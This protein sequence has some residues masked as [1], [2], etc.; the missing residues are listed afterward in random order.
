MHFEITIC[1]MD[2]NSFVVYTDILETL[3]ELNDEEVGRL[4]R[5]MVEYVEL[6]NK[7][8]FTGKLRLT[9]IPIRQ[10]LDRDAARWEEIRVKRSEAGRI[11][12]QNSAKKR[13]IVHGDV[14]GALHGD[15]SKQANA[16]NAPAV[17]NSRTAGRSKNGSEANQAVNVNVNGNV[18]V[19][20]NEDVINTASVPDDVFSVSSSVLSYLNEKCGCAYQPTDETTNRFGELMSE[21][22]TV[23]DFQKVIDTKA[24]E[25]LNEPKMRRY[26]RPSTLFGPKFTDYIAEPVPIQLLQDRV[27]EQNRDELIRERDALKAAY[28]E[29]DARMREIEIDPEAS[30]AN[31]GEWQ[32]LEDQRCAVEK[33]MMNL[34]RRLAQI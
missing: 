8:K 9:F 11:G 34:N 27:A 17:E 33:S 22:Y 13:Q 30:L 32:N 5:A 19:N 25:W 18:N 7:P 16:S 28:Y 31:W 20:V 21:G 6:G 12:G 4:F 1:D 24:S 2:K 15:L 14:H 10:Q 3:N 29:I 23:D 26:L